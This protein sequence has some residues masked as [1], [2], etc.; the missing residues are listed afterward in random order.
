[1]YKIHNAKLDAKGKKF[2]IAVSRFNDLITKELLSGAIDKIL[3]SGGSEE[4]I[5]VAWVPGAFELPLVCQK[6]ANTKKYDSIIAL[7]AVIRGGTYHYELVANETA[8]GIAKVSLDTNIP[9]IFGIIA[10]DTIDQAME[11]AGAKTGNKGASASEAAIEM[12]NL[13]TS[14]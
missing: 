9:I 3:R 7:G 2:G 14:F 11:R 5:E 8:K 12:A 13:L 6:M 1:M 10:C 4:N